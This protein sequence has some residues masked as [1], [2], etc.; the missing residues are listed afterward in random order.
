MTIVHTRQGTGRVLRPT[1]VGSLRLNHNTWLGAARLPKNPRV[2]YRSTCGAGRTGR[3]PPRARGWRVA[4]GW[5]TTRLSFSVCDV[6][7][8]SAAHAFRPADG[9]GGGGARR[10][11][12]R[13]HG[14][15]EGTVVRLPQPDRRACARPAC[16]APA[17]ATLSFSYAERR[18]DLSVLLDQPEP[19]TYDLCTA[20][21]ARSRPPHGWQLR[22]RRP[23][24]TRLPDA[25][26]SVPADLG[27]DRTVA[28]LAAALRAVPGAVS[29]DAAPAPTAEIVPDL[30]AL[31]ADALQ[32]DVLRAD[33][34]R[35]DAPPAD[36]RQPRPVPAARA[37]AGQ[38]VPRPSSG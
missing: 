22:D 21:A 4:G 18:V 7:D 37:R 2:G 1:R 25:R 8:G 26:P 20:H 35:A 38:R 12:Q 27:G 23:E 19:Q 16:P 3:T 9:V 24:D 32:A 5:R 30:P 34:L 28:V 17:V 14:G 31:R 33:V 15:G 11:R 36:A 6:D 10:Q 13:G 29:E